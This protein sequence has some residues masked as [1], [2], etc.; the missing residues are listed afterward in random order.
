M[1]VTGFVLPPKCEC[2]ETRRVYFNRAMM[3]LVYGNKCNKCHAKEQRDRRAWNI[4]NELKLKCLNCGSERLIGIPVECS[5]EPYNMFSWNGIWGGI[6]AVG[7]GIAAVFNWA[8][9]RS[10]LQNTPEMQAAKKAADAQK[11]VD[12]NSK[13]V[14]QGNLDEIR[15]R[16]GS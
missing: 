13:I 11:E 1:R 7:S 2:G 9:G 12:E 15:K 14:Q 4:G 10:T 6:C 5:T 8:T 16:A 3:G